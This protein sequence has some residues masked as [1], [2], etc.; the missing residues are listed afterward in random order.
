[1]GIKTIKFNDEAYIWSNQIIT[2]DV[3]CRK[4]A[5]SQLMFATSLVK[6]K[7]NAMALQV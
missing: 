6:I 2:I 3:T 5:Y 1:M 4:G 7:L